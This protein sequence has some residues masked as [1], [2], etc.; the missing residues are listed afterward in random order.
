MEWRCL[1]KHMFVESRGSELKRAHPARQVEPATVPIRIS[2]LEFAGIPHHGKLLSFGDLPEGSSM[3]ETT[4][5]GSGLGADLEA[6]R[7]YP[8]RIP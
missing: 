2:Y 4:R 6:H 8:R 7:I 3:V 5:D 1:K